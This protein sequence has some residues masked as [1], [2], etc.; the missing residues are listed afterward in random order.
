MP[1]DVVVFLIFTN[2]PL[3]SDM[4]NEVTEAPQRMLYQNPN[5]IKKTKIGSTFNKNPTKEKG[6]KMS[7]KIAGTTVTMHGQFDINI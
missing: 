2:I 3:Q 7:S 6:M 4:K 5:L 1:K